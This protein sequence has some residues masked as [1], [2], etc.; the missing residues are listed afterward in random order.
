MSVKNTLLVGVIAMA[1]PDV[2]ISQKMTIDS[3]ETYVLTHTIYLAGDSAYELTRVA[4]PRGDIRFYRDH[5]DQDHLDGTIFQF[6][7]NKMPGHRKS[8]A[9][10]RLFYVVRHSHL[11]NMTDTLRSIYPIPKAYDLPKDSAYGGILFEEDE[12]CEDAT[13]SYVLREMGIDRLNDSSL[14]YLEPVVKRPWK[15][16]K[17]E[18]LYVLYEIKNFR[19]ENTEV[20]CV[21]GENDTEQG[22]NI[23]NRNKIWVKPRRMRI[24]VR[25]INDFIALGRNLCLRPGLRGRLHMLH[26]DGKKYTMAEHCV[27]EMSRGEFKGLSK[28]FIIDNI[29]GDCGCRKLW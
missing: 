15:S 21:V 14:Y 2:C 19:K 22:F 6:N 16:K 18:L 10:D 24:L 28:L 29:L 1:W 9:V 20:I 7:R 5:I 17:N 27:F 13:H 25:E 3:L 23:L 12:L 11:V 8:K 4:D 26:V